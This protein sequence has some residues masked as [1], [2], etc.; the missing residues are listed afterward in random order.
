MSSFS[1]PGITSDPFPAIIIRV[2]NKEVLI[3]CFENIVWSYFIYSFNVIFVK[4]PPEGLPF[5]CLTHS[6]QR[7]GVFYLHHKSSNIT[8]FY[9][10]KYLFRNFSVS[11]ISLMNSTTTIGSHVL[12]TDED[13]LSLKHICQRL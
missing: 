13:D 10:I 1:R 11:F 9:I 5:L 2:V 4:N 12:L 3:G 6:E 8:G 7:T